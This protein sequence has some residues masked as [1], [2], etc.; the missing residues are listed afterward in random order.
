MRHKPSIFTGGYAPDGSIKWIEEVEIIFEAVGC[1][2]VNKTTLET[3]VLREEANQ[4]WKNAKLRM[5]A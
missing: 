5:G 1:S 2:E 3:Y 4:W